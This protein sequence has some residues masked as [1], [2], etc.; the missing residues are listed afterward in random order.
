VGARELSIFVAGISMGERAQ[1]SSPP[2]PCK[3]CSQG[4]I[5]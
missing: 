5:F 1:N 4:W 2:Q 3:N